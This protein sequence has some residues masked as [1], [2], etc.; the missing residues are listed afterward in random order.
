MLVL[1]FREIN[2]GNKTDLRD[3]FLNYDS[4]SVPI[5]EID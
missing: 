1:Q 4:V 5:T 3:I 2:Q